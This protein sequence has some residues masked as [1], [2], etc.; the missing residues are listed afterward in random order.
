MDNAF[1][2]SIDVSTKKARTVVL[3]NG[4]PTAMLY[5]MAQP[6]QPIYGKSQ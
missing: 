1:P 2:G 5:Q 3:F 4:T 6:G